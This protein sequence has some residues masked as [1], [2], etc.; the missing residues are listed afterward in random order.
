MMKLSD[1]IRIAQPLLVP[2]ALRVDPPSQGK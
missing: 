1:Y 2:I